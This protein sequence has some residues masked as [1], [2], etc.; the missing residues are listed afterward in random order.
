MSKCLTVQIN[1]ARLIQVAITGFETLI[2]TTTRSRLMDL[3]GLAVR[4]R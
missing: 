3:K 1:A 4:G 2:K